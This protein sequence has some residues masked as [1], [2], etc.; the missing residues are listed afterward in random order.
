[1]HI[2]KLSLTIAAFCCFIF[3]NAQFVND[4][5]QAADKYYAK[6]DYYSAAQ[7]YEKHLA[8]G[9][10]KSNVAGFSPYAVSASANKKAIAASSGKQA[11]IYNLAESYRKLHFHE[12][13]LPYYQ[14]AAS[15]DKAAFPLAGYYY[16]TTLKS[17]GKY[18][19]AAIAF[20]SFSATYSQEDIYAESAKKEIKS[21]EFI[22][23]QL[24][25]K[26]LARYEVQKAAGLG[27]EGGTY[28]PVWLNDET[29][30]FTSTR[31]DATD[32]NKSNTNRLYQT[33]YSNNAA[34]AVV[35]TII[36]QTKDIQQG[37]AAVTPKGNTLF[38]SRWEISKEKTSAAIYS[39][40]KTGESW[41]EP[42]Q[43][44]ALNA[45]GSNSQQPF[46]MPDGK[47]LLFS[48]DRAAGIGGFD[49][50]MA[51]LDENGSVSNVTNMGNNIN[52]KYDE[53]APSYHTASNTLVFSSNGHV[54]MGGYDFFYSKETAGS[55]SEPK[56]FGYPV[57]S[58]KDDLYFIS[59]GSA[60]NI[61]ENVIMSSDRDA[62][63]CL[64]LFSLSKTK[65][66]KQISGTV[67]AC[68][69][70]QPMG[71]V[72]VVIADANNKTIAT[73]TT[74]A[75]GNYS[76]NIPEFEQL[77]ATATNKGY[78]ANSLQITGPADAEEEFF[79]NPLLCLNIIP[80]DAIKVD[81]V[82]YDFNKAT[83]Q[84][85]SF[86]ELDKL[87]QLLNDNPNMLIELAAHTDSKGEDEYNQALS[88][89]RAKSVVDYLISKG[90]DKGRLMPKGY[91]ETMPVAENTNADG[92]DN[93]EGRQQ[94][95]RTEF[96]VLKN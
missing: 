36:P 65:A 20:N 13:A 39:S 58:V 93:P 23:Q 74:D 85:A 22:Q 30:L 88:D 27:S 31:P 44:S 38:I 82:Y 57:N 71:G 28:A 75:A 73:K 61:L 46:V 41:S 90:I 72:N 50:W 81:N 91:G 66:L 7:Y 21:L 47:K 1:M 2:K 77:K 49:I 24:V 68:D 89:A 67:I 84:E 26:D 42:V 37:V 56:N 12:K 15:F 55:F 76:F 87:V 17:L 43:V 54:G 34:G 16:A 4:Y 79:T 45:A 11:I 95:R 25:R 83:L 40:T 60:T 64:E 9:K 3:A 92:T 69:T 29:L 53:Q 62:A 78:F 94:N 8:Q 5:L 32:K 35:K 96:K 70:K 80:E 48:S 63:C 51:D 10:G 19:E 59:K 6:G 86:P 33:S 14:E 52:T 18:D